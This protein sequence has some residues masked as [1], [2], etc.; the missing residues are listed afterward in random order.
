MLQPIPLE[1]LTLGSFHD[2]PQSRRVGL[3]RTFRSERHESS[4]T[5]ASDSESRTVYPFTFSFMGS[6]QLG[7]QYTLW[8]DSEASRKEWQQKLLHAKALRSADI[9]ANKVRVI[10]RAQ[11]VRPKRLT[12]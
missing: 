10:W 2:P 4:T 9:E 3:L 6:G 12:L 8:A 5:P 7:G 11:T 1:L